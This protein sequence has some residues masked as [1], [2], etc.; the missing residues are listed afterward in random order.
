[1]LRDRA[2][3]TRFAH[4]AKSV[5]VSA[6]LAAETERIAEEAHREQQEIHRAIVTLFR[7][8]IRHAIREQRDGARLAAAKYSSEPVALPT[9]SCSLE[10]VSF[11]TIP[12]NVPTPSDRLAIKSRASRMACVQNH[13]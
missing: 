9:S 6:L 10:Y 13:E 11:C 3:T 4:W 2:H 7:Q 8:V 5:V 1:M 12:I